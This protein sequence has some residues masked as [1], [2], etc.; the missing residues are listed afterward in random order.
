MAGIRPA[1]KADNDISI[2]AQDINNLTFALITPLN[3]YHSYIRH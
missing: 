1:L 3:P 2:A